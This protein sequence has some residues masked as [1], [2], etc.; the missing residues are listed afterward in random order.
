MAGSNRRKLNFKSV[1]VLRL[2]AFAFVFVGQ[3]VPF[4]YSN[5]ADMLP[6]WSTMSE[7]TYPGIGLAFA[8]SGFLLTAHIHREY[9]YYGRFKLLNY[10][11]RR[12]FKILP[13]YFFVVFLGFI[14]IP[15]LIDFLK[16]NE[17]DIPEIWPFLTLT[18]HL[19]LVDHASQ[20]P[21][22][23]LIL[24]PI[25]VLLHIYFLWGILVKFLWRR[26][27]ELAFTL[28]LLS[29]LA[30]ILLTFL[31]FNAYYLMTGCSTY[32]FLGAWGA[33]EARKNGFLLQKFKTLPVAVYSSVHV[34]A[35]SL[36]LGLPFLI[37]HKWLHSIYWITLPVLFVAIIWEQNFCKNAPFKL[38]KIKWMDALGTYSYGLYMYHGIG[39]GLTIAVYDT[40]AVAK[41]GFILH[42]A[43]PMFCLMIA[44]VASQ[45]SYSIIE[46]PF[47]RMRR[48]FKRR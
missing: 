46:K 28:F 30:S 7:L 19:F 35:W 41:N 34:I 25:C 44:I 36:A 11:T 5:T 42:F 18:V 32:F 45:F 1:N 9:K 2:I 38:K 20:T 33:L 26:I 29:L 23:I 22:F 12:G 10:W 21:Y 14:A 47:L 8:L 40:I 31:N 6:V 24:W 13:L 48:Q 4:Q 39:L 3:V 15:N 37:G 27:S 17:V 43:F 16:I